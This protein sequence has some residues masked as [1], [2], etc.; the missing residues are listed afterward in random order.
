MNKLLCFLSGGHRFKDSNL[1][2]YE[3]PFERRMAVQ[4]FCTKCGEEVCIS[5]PFDVLFD[6]EDNSPK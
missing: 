5:I 1:K 3:I 2:L 6:K 4:Q